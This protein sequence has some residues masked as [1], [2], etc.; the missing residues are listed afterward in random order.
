MTEQANRVYVT[1]VNGVRFFV[2]ADGPGHAAFQM[3]GL[4]PDLQRAEV[5]RQVF[6]ARGVV[7]LGQAARDAARDP[8]IKV[9]P[10]KVEKMS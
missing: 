8:K 9:I 4:I 10:F 6:I 3:L 1:R 2:S 7:A 5:R